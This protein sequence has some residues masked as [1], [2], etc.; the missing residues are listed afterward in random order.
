METIIDRESDLFH[1]LCMLIGQE[2]RD[3]DFY[4]TDPGWWT[5][6]LWTRRN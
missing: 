2:G 4:E 3:W 6:W 1:G 5:L